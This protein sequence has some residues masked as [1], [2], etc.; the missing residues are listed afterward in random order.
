VTHKHQDNGFPATMWNL[1]RLA[2]DPGC[3]EYCAAVNELITS[4]W[5]PVFYFIRAKGFRV[6]QAEDLTQ[7]FFIK[8]LERGW[9]TKADPTRGKFRTFLLTILIRFLSDQGPERSPRQRTFDARLVSVSSLLKDEEKMFDPPSY[10]T[11]E[12]IYMKQWALATIQA[13]QRKLEDWCR[14]NDRSSWYQMF[15]AVHFQPPGSPKLSQMALAGQMGVS[16]DQVRYALEQTNQ[17]FIEFLRAEVAGQVDSDSHVD[18]ELQQL[19]ELLQ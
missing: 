12:S 8:L 7:E 6:H 1:I 14:L 3:D 5:R 17:Q 10:E 18:E 11:P 2:M 13:A 4:Y 19:E 9:I 15:Q 16:R